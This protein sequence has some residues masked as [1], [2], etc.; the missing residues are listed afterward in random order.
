MVKG[1]KAASSLRKHSEK[2]CR[3]LAMPPASKSALCQAVH[4]A[5]EK[6]EECKNYGPVK[7]K[8][9]R[10]AICNRCKKP[11]IWATTVRRKPIALEAA[12]KK[13][14][15]NIVD[16]IAVPEKGGPYVC[17]WVKCPPTKE[18]DTSDDPLQE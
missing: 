1:A 2:L 5:G 3:M 9:V 14:K 11:I 13:G 8:P 10:E 4:V 12:L 18:P 15:F 17:H 6:F 7:P 16:D